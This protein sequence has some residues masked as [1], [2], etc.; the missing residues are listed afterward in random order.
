MGQFEVSQSKVNQLTDLV[1]T[2][3]QLIQLLT[4]QQDQRQSF[5]LL[6]RRFQEQ[7]LST[8]DEPDEAHSL[9]FA[10]QQLE[11]DIGAL[12]A[13]METNQAHMQMMMMVSTEIQNDFEQQKMSMEKRLV[14][15]AEELATKDEMLLRYQEQD[16]HQHHVINTTT[17]P[18]SRTS[19]IND[20]FLSSPT[21]SRYPS[22]VSASSISSHAVTS[23]SSLPSPTSSSPL[24]PCSPPLSCTA[25]PMIPA[26]SSPPPIIPLP[27]IPS[28]LPSPPTV[29]TSTSSTSSSSSFSSLKKQQYQY[30]Q[31]Q[32]QQQLRHFYQQQRQKHHVS[33]SVLPPNIISGNK[34]TLDQEA[35]IDPLI[36]PTLRA[37][38]LDE[39]NHNGNPFWRNMK[40]KWRTS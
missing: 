15:M 25:P 10:K 18:I 6:E 38:S 1:K 19:M 33:A 28:Q 21:T 37:G 39:L 35:P 9:H 17:P 23:Q 5:E 34:I 8:N 7:T 14:A 11:S 4:D 36:S 20:T 31:T 26:A 29:S 3:D 22:F 16:H 24:S 30:Q 13:N 40:N 12:K 32:Q 2:Q 27:P